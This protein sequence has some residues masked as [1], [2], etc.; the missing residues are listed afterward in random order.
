MQLRGPA[1]ITALTPVFGQR[2]PIF[3]CRVVDRFECL[4]S[5]G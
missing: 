1:D 5:S 2:P 4:R 3:R